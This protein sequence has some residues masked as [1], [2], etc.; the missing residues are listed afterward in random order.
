MLSYGN[1][2]KIIPSEASE[3]IVRKAHEASKEK[4]LNIITLGAMTNLATAILTDSTIVPKLR[5]YSLAMQY[6]KA[7]KVWNKNE[8][9]IRSD[10]DAFDLV[11]NTDNLEIHIMPVS[12]SKE[13]ILDKDEIVDQMKNRGEPW[14]FLAGRA[15]EKF[16]ERREVVISDV[17]LIEAILKPDY[18]KEEQT[19]TPPE[20]K[21][22]KVF[23]YT[24]INKEFMKIDFW[25]AVKRYISD[26]S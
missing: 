13:L 22:R 14:D 24:S 4:K 26:N 21:S 16:P 2:E 25:K 17:A 1:E 5:V 7:T 3:F 6:D 18:A 10:L 19:N 20:N 23:V 9:N 8:L 15:L 12:T 11:L